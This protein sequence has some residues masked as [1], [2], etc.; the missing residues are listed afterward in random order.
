MSSG[1]AQAEA[2]RELV[3]TMYDAAIDGE[4]ERF[5]AC[6]ADDLVVIEPSYLPYGGVHRGIDS[7]LALFAEV[8]E[9]LDLGTLQ[10]SGLVADGEEVVAFLSVRSVKDRS[11]VQIAERSIVRDGKIVEMKV[12]FHELGGLLADIR[13]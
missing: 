7:F 4:T 1:Q 5:I 9:Y 10:L 6:L 8:G 2:S 11:E 13:R 12:M 3:Q